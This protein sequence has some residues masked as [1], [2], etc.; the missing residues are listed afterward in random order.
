MR[1]SESRDTRNSMILVPLLNPKFA[2]APAARSCELRVRGT[3]VRRELA[4]GTPDLRAQLAIPERAGIRAV[5]SIVAHMSQQWPAARTGEC[6]DVR[7]QC[8][9]WSPGHCRLSD[10]GEGALRF[11]PVRS[12]QYPVHRRA[13][14][15]LGRHQ[16]DLG[17]P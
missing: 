10:Q 12:R 17:A 1:T 7:A 15:A 8:S 13:V 5:A 6:I 3:S 16:D 14:R 2:N 11:R 9:E 4:A